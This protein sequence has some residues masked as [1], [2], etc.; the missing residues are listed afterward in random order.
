MSLRLGLTSASGT[1][2]GLLLLL[3]WG[4]G[5]R[6]GVWPL[7][8]T[9]ACGACCTTDTSFLLLKRKEEKENHMEVFRVKITNMV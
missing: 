1:D 7:T 2:C 8:T 9:E 3:E 6:L 5:E 4:F